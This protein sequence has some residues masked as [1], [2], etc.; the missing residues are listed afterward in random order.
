MPYKHVVLTAIRHYHI[1]SFKSKYQNII[2]YFVI[3]INNIMELNI[4]QFM[5][6]LVP[7]LCLVLLDFN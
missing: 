3:I 5:E 4:R 7:L 6:C 1:V 2:K